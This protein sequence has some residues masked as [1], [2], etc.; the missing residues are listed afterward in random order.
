MP[1]QATKSG[2]LLLNLSPDFRPAT[3]SILT[4]WPMLVGVTDSS[5]GLLGEHDKAMRLATIRL[6]M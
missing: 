3:P 4:K 1:A 2:K 6:N 5:C